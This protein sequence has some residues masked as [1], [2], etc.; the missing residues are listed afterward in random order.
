MRK[1]ENGKE[2]PA[3]LGEYRDLMA[4]LGGEKCRAVKYL[5]AHIALPGNG[6]DAEV[7]VHDSQMRVLLVPLLI[8]D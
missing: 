5:D 6:R 4:A 3:T 2:C 1:D 8:T 7:I